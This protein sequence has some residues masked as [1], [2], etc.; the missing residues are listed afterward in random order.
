MLKGMLII[1]NPPNNQPKASNI[2][3]LDWNKAVRA[4]MFRTMTG[5]RR[6][7]PSFSEE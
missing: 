3:N 4:I 5:A 7:K 6:R 1:A 2:N